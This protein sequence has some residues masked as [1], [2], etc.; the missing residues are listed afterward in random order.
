MAGDEKQPVEQTEGFLLGALVTGQKAIDGKLTDLTEWV[1][2]VHGLCQQ[3]GA[4]LIKHHQRIGVIEGNYKAQ[5]AR[6]EEE[7]RFR[8]STLANVVVGLIVGAMLIL[9]GAK[10]GGDGSSSPAGLS[11]PP[12]VETQAQ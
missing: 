10:W 11:Q 8:R 1:K 3:N 5:K 9:V 4:E 6:A 7:G 2:G 12:A